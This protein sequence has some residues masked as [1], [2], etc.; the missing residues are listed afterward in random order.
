MNRI[1]LC[2][3]LTLAALML[4]CAPML[5][6]AS[7]QIAPAPTLLNYQ[8]RLA[9]PD[10]TPVPD[11]T[12]SIRFSLWD[13]A[14]AGTEKWNQTLASVTV[15]NGTFAVLL[16]T[17]AAGL[18]SGDLWLETQ[19][20]TDAALTPRQQLVSVA[21]AMKANSVP[22]GSITGASIADGS[23]TGTKFATGALDTLS[24]LLGGNAITNPTTQF[25]GTTS[26]QPLAFKTNSTEHMRLLANGRLGLGT[27][28]PNSR[29]EI[30]AASVADG[31]RLIGS[32]GNAPMFGFFENS[33]E[34]GSIGLALA[35]GQYSA[36]AVSGD[37][38]L[39]AN[40]GKLHLQNGA[41]AAGITLVN[42]RVGI[43]TLTPTVPL[44]VAGDASFSGRISAAN[45]TLNDELTA[46]KATLSDRLMANLATIAD[47]LEVKRVEINSGTTRDVL[48]ATSSAPAGTWLGLT[49]TSTGGT[50]W[51][52]NSAGS[53]TLDR[54]G[55]LL[56]QANS[57]VAAQL[58]PTG[59]FIANVV[60]I[61]GGSDV[62]EPYNVAPAG[63]F[64]PVAGMLV[65]IDE[66]KVGQMRVAS[67]AY[68]STVAGIISGANGINPG[69]T[70][71]QKGTIADG[72]FPVASIGRVWCWCDADANGEIK[73]GDL[74]TSSDTPGHAMK[75][76]D[77]ERRDGAVIGKAMS[78]LKSGKGLVLV[79]VSLK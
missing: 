21:Y 29:L 12:Y 78:S 60:T 71:R 16:N 7:A 73:A 79:L 8:G 22:D 66:A 1:S 25:L 18:F 49:N 30:V 9:A 76:T 4:P 67:R 24:W 34:R 69:I 33:S 53:G 26:N 19:I 74:L 52:L 57:S 10:G 23:L 27:P 51:N 50:T 58:K 5:R 45:A 55:S 46:V 56:F 2:A 35:S 31:L 65:V 40:T 54:A 68:D 36:S 28:S 37:I 59:E 41:G 48:R 20:G 39:R 13:A 43:G 72:E 70:L 17:N 62:A 14:T 47:L 32:S 38:V 15:K 61:M 75:A 44:S 64:K 77:R 11:G 3:H 42:N 6:P 63:E